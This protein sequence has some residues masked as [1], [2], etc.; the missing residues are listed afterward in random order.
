VY[1]HNA[2]LSKA[3]GDS[4]VGGEVIASAGN[5]GEYSTGF[6]LHFELWMDGYALNPAD[7]FNFSD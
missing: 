1:K 4:V 6:H 5:T 3:Q 7:F 2:A